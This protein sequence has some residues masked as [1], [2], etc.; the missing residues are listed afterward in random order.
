MKTNLEKRGIRGAAIVLGSAACV[1]IATS[2]EENL[3]IGPNTFSATVQMVV[4]HDTVIIGDTSLATAKVTDASG[5][6]V[7][8]LKFDWSSADSSV[9]GFAVPSDADGATGRTRRL[10]GRKPGVA[11]VGL[12]LN[13]SRFVT[14]SAARPQT[15]VVGGVKVLTSHDTTL[16]AINDTGMVVAASL[17][18]ANGSLINRFSLGVKWTHL[19][20]HTTV[21]GQGDTIRY[22]AKSNGPDTLIATHEFCIAGGKCAD[23][24]VARVGQL[25]TMT[26]STHAFNAWSFGD[27]IGPSVVLADRRGSGLPGTSVRFVPATAADSAIVRLTTPIGT[28]NPTTGALA[29]PLLISQ[30]N[31]TAKVRVQALL[32]DGFSIVAIDSITATVRQVARRVGLEPLRAVVDFN[33]SIP[34]KSVAR[35]ARGAAIPDATVDLVA[36]GAQ[37]VNGWMGPVTA[38]ANPVLAQVTATLTGVALPDSNP[39]APQ[40]PVIAL[41]AT[42]TFV[43]VDTVTAGA[44]SKGLSVLAVDS[45]GQP[46]VGKWVRFGVDGGAVPDSVQLDAAGTASFTWTPGDSAATYVLTAI[47]ATAATLETAADSAGRIVARRSIVVKPDVASELKS[48][49]AVD[50]TN[51]PVSA[52]TNVT[53]TIRD[54]FNNK[55]K[56]ATAADFTTNVTGGGTLGVFACTEG[57]CTATYTAP[58][59]PGPVTISVSVGGVDILGSPINMV[60]H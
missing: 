10:I 33:D 29:A 25:L 20:T 19:G 53:V 5:R 50:F 4:A 35:D 15:V 55:I 30:G 27:S 7:L 34:V 32:P 38:A 21:I 17:V 42:I 44:T 46:A 36:S 43:K 18:K 45:L 47:R 31:G 28:S 14:G 54:K 59:A 52:T 6:E 41:P 26:L 58:A 16:T 11:N 1:A 51:I 40:V 3:P 13:D 23:T 9:V 57:V 56:T 8:G 48:T 37:I 22:V 60:I 24:V 12:S 49:A 39:A 2:C